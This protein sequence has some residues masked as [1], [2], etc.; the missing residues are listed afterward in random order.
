MLQLI[1]LVT[2]DRFMSPGMS[3]T[4]NTDSTENG[5]RPK[6]CETLLGRAF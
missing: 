3:H 1:L 4:E 5:K 6:V 2:G